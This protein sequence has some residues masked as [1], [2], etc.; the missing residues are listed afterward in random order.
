MTLANQSSNFTTALH[1][2]AMECALRRQTKGCKVKFGNAKC[3]NCRYYIASYID[4]DPRHVH[5]FMME[6]ERDVAIKRHTIDH[7]NTMAAIPVL[8]VLAFVAFIVFVWVHQERKADRIYNEKQIAQQAPATVAKQDEIYQ[9]IQKVTADLQRK[10][11]V[12]LDGKT[13]CIDAA[14]L[15]YQYFPDK[16]RVTIERNVNTGTDFNHLFNCVLINGTWRAIEPQ[17]LYTGHRSSYWMRDVWGDSY[18]N[19]FNVD[20]TAKWKVFAK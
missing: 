11:D 10:K 15:F 19:A 16:S 17:S 7:D 18:N 9:T 6:A 5:L 20:E 12:N 1:N 4:A 14:V 2:C 8:F 3:V 13:N